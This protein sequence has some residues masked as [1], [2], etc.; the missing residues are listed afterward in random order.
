MPLQIH[1][2]KN[3][4]EKIKDHDGNFANQHDKNMEAAAERLS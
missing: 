3:M 4:R 2:R 1:D